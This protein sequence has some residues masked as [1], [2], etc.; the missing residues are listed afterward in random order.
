MGGI[1]I[2]QAAVVLLASLLAAMQVTDQRRTCQEGR[3]WFSILLLPACPSVSSG[4]LGKAVVL[5]LPSLIPFDWTAILAKQYRH[6][7]V[8]EAL[9]IMLH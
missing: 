8:G 9:S 1:H 7:R 4:C 2:R 6:Y 3:I 5:Q